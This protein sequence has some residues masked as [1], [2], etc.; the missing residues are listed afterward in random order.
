MTLE[1][2]VQTLLRKSA[3]DLHASEAS[4][5]SILSILG[6]LSHMSRASAGTTELTQLLVHTVSHFPAG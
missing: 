4:Y 6:G 3:R 2:A 5:R 1:P